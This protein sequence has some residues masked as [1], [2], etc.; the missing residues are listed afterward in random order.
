MKN[1]FII[2][3]CVFF[4]HL[5]AVSQNNIDTKEGTNPLSTHSKTNS[6]TVKYVMFSEQNTSS[7]ILKRDSLYGRPTIGI[8]QKTQSY[9]YLSYLNYCKTGLI[10]K[11]RAPKKKKTESVIDHVIDKGNSEKPKFD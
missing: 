2:V 5:L 9:H 3:L 4:V 6:N 7:L 11:K 10:V 1:I 8:L